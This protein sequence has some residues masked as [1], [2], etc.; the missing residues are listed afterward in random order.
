MKYTTKIY[1]RES[2]WDMY[3]VGEDEYGSTIA[4][5]ANKDTMDEK[6]YNMGWESYKYWAEEDGCTVTVHHVG[7]TA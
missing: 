6:A 4:V 2:S 3:I 7:V 1:V 5:S